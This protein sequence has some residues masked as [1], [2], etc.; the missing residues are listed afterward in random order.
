MV[1]GSEITSGTACFTTSEQGPRNLYVDGLT[2]VRDIGGW[3][4]DSG[5]V[6]Q[7][8]IYRCGRLN[9]SYDDTPTIEITDDGIFMMKEVLEVKLEIDLRGYE[10]LGKIS[11]SP[12]GNDVN[13]YR[14]SMSCG[15]N[16]L[17]K[18]VEQIK[19][20]FSFLANEENYPLIVHCNIGTDRTGLIAFLINGLLGV[21]EDGLYLDYVF[22]NF[23]SIG[24]GRAS[25]V[26]SNY[27]SIFE[28]CEGKSLNE[29]IYNYL[30]EIG[31]KTTD[32]DEMIALMTA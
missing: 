24:G 3:K 5:R 22:S 6:K 23:G 16:I 2:N 28:S 27:L 8:M 17:T 14:E 11:A 15:G 19:N 32:M 4:T 20:I 26:I 25:Q 1:D 29:K 13:Y 31:I 30:S 7:G 10:E 12:L 21:S 18:N 9:L